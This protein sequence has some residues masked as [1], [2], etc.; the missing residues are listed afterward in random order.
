[1]D[2]PNGHGSV[3]GLLR[4]ALSR[5]DEQGERLAAIHVSHAL[6][7]LTAPGSRLDGPGKHP[8]PD[9]DKPDSHSEIS[10]RR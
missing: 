8:Q 9:S 1:M 4:E 3:E 6:D 10:A 5:L 7:V 2:A